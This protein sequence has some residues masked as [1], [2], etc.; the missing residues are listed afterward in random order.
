M[1]KMVLENVE[2]DRLKKLANLHLFSGLLIILFAV[3]LS[4]IMVALM[5]PYMQQITTTNGTV[6]LPPEL[7]YHMVT[8][9]SIVAI[10]FNV[11]FSILYYL[12]STYSDIF[13]DRAYLYRISNYILILL[14]VLQVISSA[15]VLMTISP[16]MIEEF[17][18]NTYGGGIISTP[19]TN[20]YANFAFQLL[21][22]FGYAL[23]GYSVYLASREYEEYDVL[24]I[25]SILLIIGGIITL[26]P[27]LN[28][29]GSLMIVAS[30]FILYGELRSLST[31]LK[32]KK[33]GILEM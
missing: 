28:L 16:E 12:M 6:V 26:I 11:L 20:A 18:Q 17:M 27:L 33:K 32:E 24:R 30:F 15:Y 13:Q 1:R 9:T 5:A 2:Y 29:I 31:K 21:Y 3:V 7:V 4:A 22:A 23:M 14:F 19:P 8:A 10:I 25:G